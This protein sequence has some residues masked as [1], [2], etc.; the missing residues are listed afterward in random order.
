V[1]GVY[2][3]RQL[4]PSAQQLDK[5]SRNHLSTA[6]KRSDF[7]GKTGQTL[8]LHQVPRTACERI[9]LVGCGSRKDLNDTSYQKIINRIAV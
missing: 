1:V 4:T 8:L 5:L 7:R 2:E 9:L 3:T 6:L